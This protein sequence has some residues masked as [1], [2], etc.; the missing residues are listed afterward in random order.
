LIRKLSPRAL[1]RRMAGSP[2]AGLL[3][4]SELYYS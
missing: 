4:H 1:P 3:G 2:M